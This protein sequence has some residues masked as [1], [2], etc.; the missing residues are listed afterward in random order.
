MQVAD[1]LLRRADKQHQQRAWIAFPYAV[2]KKF[3]D[4][5]AGNLAALIAYYGFLSLFPLMMVLV[6][7][8]GLL[9]RNNPELQD[10]I[11]TSALANFPV[12]G[13]QI[14]SNIHSLRGSGLALGIGLGL[15]LWA[16]LGVMK[17]LQTAMNAVWNVPYRHRPNFWVSLLRAI[18][19]LLVL[20]VITI[21]S[22]A[23]GSVGGGSDSWLLGILGIAM[24]VV[25]N[26]VLFLLAFRILTSEDV[27]WGDVFPG[28]LGAALAWTTLQAI[29]GYI[30]SHQL[31]GASNTYGTFAIVIG[32]LAWIY[33][34]AQVTLVAAEVN[35]VRKRRLWPRAIVQPPLTEAD[36][37][38]LKSY[39]EQEE[40][41]PE[42]DVT[43]RI[44]ESAQWRNNRHPS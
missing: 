16:G 20:G 19:M 22:A 13:G 25:L 26:L 41:R 3:G 11:R 7:L 39:A 32:L 28:A 18:I 6:T 35:V 5:Q 15:A 21:A 36:E 44:E 34:G 9:L 12:L 29:G 33:L 14:S 4:D 24:S 27:T 10:T 40:R 43:V 31:Q 2:M 23:A 17:V 30:V 38:A 37:R 42:E 8:L 1:R